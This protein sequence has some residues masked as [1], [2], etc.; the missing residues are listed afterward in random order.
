[1]SGLWVWRLEQCRLLGEFAIG[2]HVG[3]VRVE[4]ALVRGGM[5]SRGRAQGRAGARSPRRG[6]CVPNVRS[7]CVAQSA[8]GMC[9]SDLA[10]PEQARSG[11]FDAYS[12]KGSASASVASHRPAVTSVRRGCGSTGSSLAAARSGS[13][14]VQTTI[15]WFVC[16][17]SSI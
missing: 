12:T 15:G 13:G 3:G 16:L 6:M 4:A 14:F 7:G 1:M 17:V 11:V 2:S 8:C 10:W 9:S 5:T